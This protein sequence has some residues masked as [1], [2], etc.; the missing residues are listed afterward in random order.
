MLC[1]CVYRFDIFVC[2]CKCDVFLV[3]SYCKYVCFC[4][5]HL[6]EVAEKR[7]IAH[8]KCFNNCL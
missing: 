6:F 4:C 2:V 5:L 8:L 1:V 3:V 7:D